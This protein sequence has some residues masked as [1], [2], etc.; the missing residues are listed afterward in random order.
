MVSSLPAVVGALLSH[1]YL[2]ES[3]Y[4]DLSQN[5]IP[6]LLSSLRLLAQQHTAP[7]RATA[8][9]AAVGRMER[10]WKRRLLSDPSNDEDDDSN[11]EFGDGNGGEK[12]YS[13]DN[14]K[15]DTSNGANAY[16]DAGNETDCLDDY[17]PS[18]SLSQSQ[19]QKLLAGKSSP[20]ASGVAVGSALV[21]GSSLSSDAAD[22][23]T[24]D[25][26][27]GSGDGRLSGTTLAQ[28]RSSPRLTPAAPHSG[29]NSMTTT[30]ATTAAAAV[31]SGGSRPLRSRPNAT[32]AVLAGSPVPPTRSRSLS[33]LNMTV[34]GVF[35][36][37][38]AEF[39]NC[40]AIA[41]TLFQGKLFRITLLLQFV[42]F[43]LSF[44][45]Y[46]FSVWVPALFAHV[47]FKSS[48]FADAFIFTL[49]Q[50]PACALGTYAV[51]HASVGRRRL[52]VA[53]A[54][55][56][57]L[58]TGI[59][60]VEHSDKT[61][62]LVLVCLYQVFTTLAWNALDCLATESFPAPARSTAFA[63]QAAAGRVGAIL[64][65][66]M[67]SYLI[68]VSVTML[69]GACAAITVFTALAG[70]ALPAGL[71]EEAHAAATCT[72]SGAAANGD[73]GGAVMVEGDLKMRQLS[74]S[75]KG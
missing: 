31:T 47:G 22:F 2:P 24:G 26:L 63:L 3:P 32:A 10:E 58:C 42:W 29:G 52:L 15:S 23:A 12:F 37:L 21:A 39:S 7:Q 20:N 11:D 72:N 40:F 53:G 30:I 75:S 5:R 66:F 13:S 46:G 35:S 6:A 74:L 55:L 17:P 19:K 25:S 57:T 18:Q 68:D 33:T 54:L 73:I 45:T 44:S 59:F 34:A 28:H 16:S 71:G 67:F 1:L 60:A 64:G 65:Q 70:L 49:A 27:G 14:S 38:A 4:F 62:A 61:L 9:L 36:A 51:D 48:R 41:S 8:A 43:S 50:V 56:T 69:L